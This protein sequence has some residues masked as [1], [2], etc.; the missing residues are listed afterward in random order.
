MM[1]ITRQTTMKSAIIFC[2][3]LVALCSTAQQCGRN[4]VYIS[5]G[6]ACRPN[7]SKCVPPRPMGPIGCAA[8]CV[9]MC[10]CAPGYFRHPSGNCVTKTNC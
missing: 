1:F 7:E 4:E 9:Q 10:A 3:L 2:L 6:S 8:V 5:C